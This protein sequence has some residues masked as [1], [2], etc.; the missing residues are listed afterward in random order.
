M[1]LPA[2]RQVMNA[3]VRFSFLKHEPGHAME[4]KLKT[5]PNFPANNLLIKVNDPPCVHFGSCE[6][7]HTANQ[8][9]FRL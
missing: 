3:C 5:P 2:G 7:G 9:G 4:T 1:S 6:P 8:N